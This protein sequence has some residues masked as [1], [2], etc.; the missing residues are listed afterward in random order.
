MEQSTPDAG[1]GRHETELER[2][3]RNLIE[4]LQEA[5]VVQTGVQILFG[6]LLT[7]AF[8]PK[9]ERLSSF[10]KA[11]YF[12][13]LVAAAATLI[14]LTAPTA[15]HRILFRQGDKEHL[16]T[17]ANRF[18]LVGLATMGLTSIGVVMLLSDIAFSPAG[19]RDR[20][21][22][23]GASP[24]RRPGASCR[25]PGGARSAGRRRDRPLPRRSGAA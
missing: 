8:Q 12:V 23:G 19:D 15:W 7:V 18:M 14:M 16:V 22:S 4:L 25:W 11:D 10:Q 6:F 9:F 3:D 5:R 2:D 1:D 17:V 24:A 21:G 20:H 13:T